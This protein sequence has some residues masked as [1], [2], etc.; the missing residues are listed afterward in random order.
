MELGASLV[1]SATASRSNVVNRD[2]RL[3]RTLWKNIEFRGL[4]LATDSY[5]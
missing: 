1:G 2:I 4:S 5:F 3:W